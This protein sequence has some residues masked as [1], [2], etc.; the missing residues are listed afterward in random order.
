[1]N[2]IRGRAIVA[3]G[4]AGGNEENGF[5]DINE[6]CEQFSS[7]ELKICSRIR[8]TVMFS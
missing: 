1:M 2:E 7:K 3:D 4:N 8:Q 6:N 5:A